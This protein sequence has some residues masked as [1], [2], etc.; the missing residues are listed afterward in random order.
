MMIT[1][2]LIGCYL[3][4]ANK[5]QLSPT[6]VTGDKLSMNVITDMANKAELLVVITP[7]I[8][9]YDRISARVDAVYKGKIYIG[10]NINI[11]I[12][13][14]SADSK[15]IGLFS[16]IFN[17]KPLLCFLTY[18]GKD[19][20]KLTFDDSGNSQAIRYQ[21]AEFAW[22]RVS[23]KRPMGDQSVI[24]NVK[25]ELIAGLKSSDSVVVD[26]CAT[27]LL[28]FDYTFLQDLLE[29]QFA[30][31]ENPEAI[32]FY[33]IYTKMPIGKR[34]D[35]IKAIEYTIK[36]SKSEQD[37][38]APN[39]LSATNIQSMQEYVIQKNWLT[40]LTMNFRNIQTQDH[41]T[42]QLLNKEIVDNNQI[43][44]FL[45]SSSPNWADYSSIPYLITVLPKIDPQQQYVCLRV[46]AKLTGRDIPSNYDFFIDQHNI[47]IADWQRWWSDEGAVAFGE[48][49]DNFQK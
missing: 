40:M 41:E 10:N 16:A 15:G 35:I 17:K 6:A 37:N 26:D 20:Y 38:K 32:R 21:Y 22:L 11:D 34:S 42:I 33:Q 27:W 43:Q 13:S 12:P 3:F 19:L 14:V 2:Y 24:D 39:N 25:N 36:L 5:E 28:R 8:I 31:K 47:V 44:S 23:D 49:R 4:A 1:L 45:I 30:H 48:M 9:K 29:T 46:L 7:Q 18:A